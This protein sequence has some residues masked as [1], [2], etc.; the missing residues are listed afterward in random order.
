MSVFKVKI[1]SGTQGLLDKH[2]TTGAQMSPSVQRTIYLMGPHKTNRKLKDGDTF[3]DSNYFKR[4]VSNLEGG[5]AVPETAILSI[6]TDDGSVY[7]DDGLTSTF[8]KVYT[9]APVINSVTSGAPDSTATGFAA[10]NVVDILGDTGSYATFL[11]LNNTGTVSLKVR[12]NGLA[13]A[14]LD[15]AASTSLVFD[16]GDGLWTKVEFGNASGVTAGAVQATVSV[17]STSNS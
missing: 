8:P 5:S 11:L 12:L 4:F 7:S 13:T 2:P 14:I 9:K 17:V 6:V 10:N 15:L 16:S 3:T 1:N